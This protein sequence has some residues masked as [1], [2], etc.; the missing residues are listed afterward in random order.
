[1]FS[2]DCSDEEHPSNVA[3]F[4]SPCAARATASCPLVSVA[5]CD[6]ASARISETSLSAVTMWKRLDASTVYVL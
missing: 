3:R 6:S 2:A 1:M 4:A 5:T